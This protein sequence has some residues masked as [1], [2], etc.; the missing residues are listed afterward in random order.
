FYDDLPSTTITEILKL[1]DPDYLV[2]IYQDAYYDMSDSKAFN[3]GRVPLQKVLE[4]YVASLRNIVAN[5]SRAGKRL[6]L[7]DYRCLLRA[8][9]VC[10]LGRES[11]GL[12]ADMKKAAIVPDTACYNEYLAATCWDGLHSSTT[13]HS[14]RLTPYT[15][16]ARSRQKRGS[17]FVNYR[18]GK[19]GKTIKAVMTRLVQEMRKNG[20][21]ANE[22]T[23]AHV[24]TA[25]S[26]EGDMGGVKDVLASIFLLDVDAI[27]SDSSIAKPPLVPTSSPFYP[28]ETLLFT[29]AHIFGSNND[30]PAALRLVDHISQLYSLPVPLATW[31]ELLYWTF[32]LTVPH[33]GRLAA[34][35]FE[36]IGSLP[37]TSFNQL[38][39][40]MINSPYD[41][42]PTME[43][44]K[45]LMSN[46]RRIGEWD[47][48][49][50]YIGRAKKIYSASRDEHLAAY[51][52]YLNAER[53]HML[54]RAS[55]ERVHH[56]RA[57]FESKDV[58]RARNLR[59]MRGFVHMILGK[60][61]LAHIPTDNDLQW[62][63]RDV[64]DIVWE[65]RKF[66]PHLIRYRTIGGVVE[67]EL[68]NPEEIEE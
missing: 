8:I 51:K 53:H 52:D 21:P 18:V 31:R 16:L 47:L 45:W 2:S 27:M 40:T 23:F 19:Y 3:M 17:K 66:V 32:V 14:F 46:S 13:R 61:T 34:E 39:K 36:N 38:F 67:L 22:E 35:W 24:M 11:E 65:N 29:I 60:P 10:A 48:M 43:I 7:A 68:R 30:I 64:P 15:M 44:I 9:R 12:W 4:G 54:G 26:R 28:T 1:L 42:T 6:R 49:R 57:V 20:T 50:V 37:G 56:A 59:T 5:M 58:I 41:L 25:L 62:D 55:R 63:R 33:Y